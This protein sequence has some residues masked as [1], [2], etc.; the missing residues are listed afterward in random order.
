MKRAFRNILNV[1]DPHKQSVFYFKT[2]WFD[3]LVFLA[4]CWFIFLHRKSLFFLVLL[5]NPLFSYPNVY[6][7]SLIGH[8]ILGPLFKG[9]FCGSFG[10]LLP[11]AINEV[12]GELFL[13]GAGSF[14]EMILPTIGI[15][16]CL[17]IYG[18]RYVLPLML[19]W[20]SVVI[21]S[22]GM[23]IV[24]FSSQ[25]DILAYGD[26]GDWA[27]ILGA[28]GLGPY[29]IWIGNGVIFLSI[30]CFVLAVWSFFYYLRHQ[31]QYPIPN[32]EYW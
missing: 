26:T 27:F 16:V 23:Y 18:G 29:Y 30:A 17:R 14:S 13:A 21:F 11:G 2:N 15:I 31:D 22:I 12:L 19:Y 25:I 9:L 5:Y 24:D 4:I 8:H 10:L 6:I 20:M 32:G 7:H 3:W 28:L 1:V